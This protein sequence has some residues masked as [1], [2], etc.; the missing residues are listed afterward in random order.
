MEVVTQCAVPGH[1]PRDSK[2]TWS[3]CNGTFW[4][5]KRTQGKTSEIPLMPGLSDQECTRVDN[6]A[7]TNVPQCCKKYKRGHWKKAHG[8]TLCCHC[9][10]WRLCPPKN[11][12]VGGFVPSATLSGVSGKLSDQ[13]GSD[14]ING[15]VHWWIHS[16]MDFGEVKEIVEARAWLEEVG[17]WDH[18]FKGMSYP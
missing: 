3:W 2:E 11:S 4:D 15:L 13:E 17:C 6:L 18:G 1:K 8:H 10:V 7:V 5:R 12:H 9:A 14:L 16:W